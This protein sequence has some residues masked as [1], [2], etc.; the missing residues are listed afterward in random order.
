MMIAGCMALSVMLYNM[1]VFFFLKAERA[2][3]HDFA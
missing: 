3:K 2:C 1:E